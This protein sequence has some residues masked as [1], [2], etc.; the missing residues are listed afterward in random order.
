MPVASADELRL[1][2]SMLDLIHK[3]SGGQVLWRVDSPPDGD[4]THRNH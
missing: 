3:A 1:H 2:E 4:G